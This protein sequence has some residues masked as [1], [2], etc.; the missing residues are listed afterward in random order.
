MRLINTTAAW[1]V[2]A[3]FAI[4]AWAQEPAN[5]PEPEAV[6]QAAAQA[7]PAEPQV[8]FQFQTGDIV[9]PNKVATL[10]LGDKYQYM[11]PDEANKLLQLWG[12]LPDDSLQGAV[13]PVGVDLMGEGRW[14]VFLSYTDEGHIDDSDAEDIDYD[15]MLE[16][17]KEGQ[18]QAN[19]QRIK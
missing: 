13:V 6:E 5:E 7:E 3:A 11:S 17:L 9:L 14:I 19:A 16:N 4:P 1:I 12:N 8:S 18:K 15:E 10:H 2:C